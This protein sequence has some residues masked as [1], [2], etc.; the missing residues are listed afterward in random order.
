MHRLDRHAI[1]ASLL[2]ATAHSPFHT[3]L[4][5]LD[6]RQFC[7]LRTLADSDPLMLNLF[8]LKGR[9]SLALLQ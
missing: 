9:V 4:S 1:S 2:H 3:V 8:S 6:L 7:L 5:R